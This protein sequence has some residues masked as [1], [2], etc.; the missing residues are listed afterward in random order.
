MFL[1]AGQRRPILFSNNIDANLQLRAKELSSQPNMI[2]AV[3]LSTCVA[4]AAGDTLGAFNI[5]IDGVPSRMY[6]VS[7]TW[8]GQFFSASADGGQV[9]L[10][11]GGRFYVANTRMP[12]PGA[13]VADSWFHRFAAAI[14]AAFLCFQILWE[15]ATSRGL[16]PV[17]A[18]IN[19]CDSA[20]K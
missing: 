3:L 20:T 19:R 9:A 4:L 5:S 7:Q 13:L 6:A 16:K 8:Q 17:F 11:G 1:D 15:R 2:R 12:T 10:N 14:T 18:C